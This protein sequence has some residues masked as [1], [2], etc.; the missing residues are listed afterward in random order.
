MAVAKNML[1]IL[2]KAEEALIVASLCVIVVLVSVQVFARYFFHGGFLWSD[3]LV[4]FLLVIVAMI[5]SA[6]AYR[7]KMHTSLDYFF[8]KTRGALR[9]IMRI[10]IEVSSV[11]FLVMLV[12]S[13]SMLALGSMRQRA[14]TLDIPIGAVY[15]AV[16]VGAALILLEVV[17]AKAVDL[18]AAVKRKGA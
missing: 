9:V 7:E 5:G 15:L 4:G 12:Y 16:P 14:F 13:G 11:F 18:A 10:V 17:L 8:A 3:E 2:R 6:I 1:S